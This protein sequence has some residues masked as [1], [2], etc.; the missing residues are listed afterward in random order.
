ME[1]S[2]SSQEKIVKVEKGHRP[3]LTNTKK[4]REIMHYPPST[5][6]T[7]YD[8]PNRAMNEEEMLEKD[9]AMKQQHLFAQQQMLR[10]K[11][12]IIQHYQNLQ[13]S[14]QNSRQTAPL[15]RHSKSSA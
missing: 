10:Q 1:T 13:Q 7:T 9:I 5:F 8:F 3:N 6:H 14:T 4:Q 11:R 12:E 15:Q 2:Q